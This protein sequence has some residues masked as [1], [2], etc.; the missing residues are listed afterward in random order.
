[1]TRSQTFGICWFGE[2]NIYST[3]F[4]AFPGTLCLKAELIQM[5][6]LYELDFMS[7]ILGM[8]SR[9]KHKAAPDFPFCGRAEEI[10]W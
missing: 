3:G 4:E 10:F 8:R 5:L 2:E 6:D 1:M 7:R 9:D